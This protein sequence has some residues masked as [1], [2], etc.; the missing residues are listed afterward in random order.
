MLLL[1]VGFVVTG[2]LI[3]GRLGGMDENKALALHKLMHVPLLVLLGV[4]V[5]PACYLA[6]RRWG[7]IK[8]V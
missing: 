4:H 7:W 6:F 1:I 3:S 5:L 8:R 2:Y